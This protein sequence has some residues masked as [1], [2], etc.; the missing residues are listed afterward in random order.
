MGRRSETVS[1]R[2]LSHAAFHWPFLKRCTRL[3]FQRSPS[4]PS[5]V[6][7]ASALLVVGMKAEVE[8]RRHAAASTPSIELLSMRT[9]AR[10]RDPDRDRAGSQSADDRDAGIVG[11]GFRPRTRWA[12]RRARRIAPLDPRYARPGKEIAVSGSR[13]R[14]S[15]DPG[16]Y[17]VAFVNGSHI[18]PH[19]DRRADLSRT[20]LANDRTRGIDHAHSSIAHPSHRRRDGRCDRRAVTGRLPFQERRRAG[21]RHRN[22]HRRQWALRV[23]DC[24]KRTSPSTRTGS[25]RTSRTSAT[26]AS[27]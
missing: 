17:R 27:R 6:L 16:R 12:D 3:A 4:P 26:I 1:R 9:C 23:R 7:S 19:L 24:A 11:R 20:A 25:C 18:V 21:Q 2:P 22:R 14:E 15:R 5:S 10:R 8:R 13:C